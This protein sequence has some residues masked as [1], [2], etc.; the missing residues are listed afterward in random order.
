M[1][2]PWH[3]KAAPDPVV[4]TD[5]LD[6]HGD[7]TLRLG[8]PVFDAAMRGHAMY[9]TFGPDGWKLEEKDENP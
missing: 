1:E 8:D 2:W 3:R 4:W 9:G 6:P 7:G 5:P